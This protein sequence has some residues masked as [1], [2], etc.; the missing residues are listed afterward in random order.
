ML[1]DA[2]GV[3]G[4]ED[5][6]E[7]LSEDGVWG[8][9]SEFRCAGVKEEVAA[10]GVGDEDGVGGGFGDGLEQGALLLGFFLGLVESVA[11]AFEQAGLAFEEDGEDD[12]GAGEEN[13]GLEGIPGFMEL[14]V[15]LEAEG[16]EAGEGQAGEGEADEGYESLEAVGG[17]F[18]GISGFVRR[19]HGGELR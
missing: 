5:G 10:V 7:V 6:A 16:G 19:R 3:F 4:V 2:L 9:A 14:G 11:E 15:G 12:G 1:H 13:P 8:E 18:R 17:W